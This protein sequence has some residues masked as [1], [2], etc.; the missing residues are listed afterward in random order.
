MKKKFS[1][2]LLAAMLL[3][4]SLAACGKKGGDSSGS[5]SSDSVS[6]EGSVSSEEVSSEVIGSEEE[7]SEVVSSEVVSSE[8]VSS[9]EE[10]S[11]VVSS[12]EESSEV[13][14]SEEESSEVVSS[15]EESS[16]EESSEEESSE[17]ESSEEESSEEESSSDREYVDGGNM[18]DE[19]PHYVSADKVLHDRKVT[20]SDRVFV[21]NGETDYV[22]IIGTSDSRAQ[23]AATFIRQQV[24]SATGATISLYID[25]DQDLM[26][27]DETIVN[28]QL[29]WTPETKYIVLDHQALEE[30][31]FISW[32]EGIDLDYSGY[33]I[34]SAGDS[35]FMKINSFYG[36]Q[37][38]AQAFL[39]EVIGYE[40]YSYDTIVYTKDGS[41]L[42]TMDIVEKPDFD[43]TWNSGYMASSSYMASPLT[44]EEVFTYINGKFCHNS[45]DYIPLSYYD[46]TNPENLSNNWFAWEAATPILQ[47]CYT[48]HGN[49]EA[50]DAM[51]DLAFEGVKKTLIEH[52][53][54][55]AL[56]FTREDYYG[57][58]ICDTCTMLKET[59]NDSLAVTY[60]FFMNDLDAM[61]QEYLQEE[62]DANGTTKRDITL[63]FFAYRQTAAAPVFGENGDY[64][65]PSLQYV[66]D[67]DGNKKNIVTYNNEIVE[68]PFHRTYENGIECNDNVG[69][70]YAPIDA[71]FEESFY[72][73][74]NKSPKETFEKWGLLSD[75]LY[76][77]IYDT[78]FTRYVVPYNSYDAIPDTLR[79]LKDAGGAFLFNQGDRQN[80]IYTGFGTL[81]T[82]LTYTLS[83]EVNLDS[84]VLVDKFFENY[85]REAAPAMRKFYNLL[86]AHM[87]QLQVE[88][89]NVFYTQRR[90][91]SEEPKYWP[92]ATLQNWLDLC[93]EAFRAIEKYKVSDPVLYESLYKHIIAETVFPRYMICQ[94]YTGYYTP[95]QVREMRT[96]FIADCKLIDYKWHAEQIS[97][98]P[99]FDSWF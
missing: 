11:E 41:T 43:L 37:T 86:V 4:T 71:C 96:S 53:N 60:M 90:T 19:A 6:S 50:Y 17:E 1:A 97:I 33:M 24:A 69:V 63:L 12:E 26:I 51:L 45:L 76:C 44:K 87:E 75:R 42:P 82:Y 20:P 46:S 66:E 81:R 47:L 59:F 65:V 62:A 88:Y 3:A 77:W 23:D 10:S 39:K 68:L 9:E 48:A 92:H 73:N 13:V 61:V 64:T 18:S 30:E 28:R 14:S 98:Q 55:A 74:E 83:H 85:F 22:I 21:Q 58:C 7:S 93:D 94:Y 91:N 16:E 5:S 15:E 72:H 38:V 79:F 54:A 27:D 67:E 84:G 80:G 49:Q 56:T 99:I 29:A 35:V 70:F 32:R 2:I 8:V 95:S 78:N 34:Q 57:H 52:P 40:W 25:A 31:A 36:Y 89:P